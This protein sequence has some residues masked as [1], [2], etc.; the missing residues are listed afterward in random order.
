[1]KIIFIF[2]RFIEELEKP[3]LVEQNFGKFSK[4]LVDKLESNF[5]TNLRNSF[6]SQIQISDFAKFENKTSGFEFFDIE[7]SSVLGKCTYSYSYHPLNEQEV[8]DTERLWRSQET[9]ASNGT[10][11]RLGW[12][13]F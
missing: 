1:M 8:V 11:L 5:V 2:S 9:N 6:L 3:F 4:I 7:E 10:D 13:L 12:K